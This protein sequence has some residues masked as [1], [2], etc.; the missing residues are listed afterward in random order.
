MV[1]EDRKLLQELS[2][3]CPTSSNIGSLMSYEVL[4]CHVAVILVI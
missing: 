1:S 2:L 4:Q 3:I